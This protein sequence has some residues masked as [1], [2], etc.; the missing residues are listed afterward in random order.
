[1]ECTITC[2]C[3]I[4]CFDHIC[5]L[6]HIEHKSDG[7]VCGNS[8]QFCLIEMEKDGQSLASA[9]HLKIV[10][11]FPQTHTHTLHH[12]PE[13]RRSAP[14]LACFTVDRRKWC[15][16]V[17]ARQEIR[18]KDLSSLFLSCFLPGVYV[19]N[20]NHI[21]IKMSHFKWCSLH[22]IYSQKLL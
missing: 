5:Q 22:D 19:W 16:G 12:R 6:I 3:E 7:C 20:P 18:F 13:T 21:E 9:A 1:M 14:S 10:L 11:Q 17:I 4:L 2:L 15:S 8:Q